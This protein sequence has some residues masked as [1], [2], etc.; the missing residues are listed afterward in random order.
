MK[1]A[2]GIMEDQLRAALVSDRRLAG[3]REPRTR[4]EGGIAIE[5]PGAREW[6]WRW[7]DGEFQLSIAD[8]PVVAV[9]TVAEAVRYT[10]ENLAE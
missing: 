5:R 8:S 1:R 4:A 7:I 9:E 3:V 10:R 2:A 6:L